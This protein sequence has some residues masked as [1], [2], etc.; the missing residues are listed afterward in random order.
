[1]TGLP[2]TSTRHEEDKDKA[3]EE[4]VLVSEIIANAHL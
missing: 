4:H 2:T 3:W 1:M